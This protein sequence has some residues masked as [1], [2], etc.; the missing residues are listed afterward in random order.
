MPTPRAPRAKGR[1]TSPT[2]P[3]FRIS[4]QATAEAKESGIGT[5]LRTLT[6]SIEALTANV[7]RLVGRVEPVSVPDDTTDTANKGAEDFVG[8]L[9][10]IEVTI[11]D[12]AH[13]I[14]SEESRIVRVIESLR[15]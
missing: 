14:N 5:A 9:S 4:A 2:G 3:D 8:G 6:S 7:N 11:Y 10:P 1:S 15:I 13:R 12:M